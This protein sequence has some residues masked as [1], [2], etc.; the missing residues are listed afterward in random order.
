MVTSQ[1]GIQLQDL[2]LFNKQTLSRASCV[3]GT[4]LGA[5][6]TSVSRQ[7][8]ISALMVLGP[9]EE[10]LAW[11][12]TDKSKMGRWLLRNWN[13]ECVPRQIQGWGGNRLSGCTRPEPNSQQ[14]RLV[15]EPWRRDWKCT[16]LCSGHLGPN[17]EYLPA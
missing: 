7:A 4:V 13:T 3:P 15:T 9:S 8:P 11:M 2:S 16:F 17:N 5:W 10:N 1:P 14:R 12:G 6:V